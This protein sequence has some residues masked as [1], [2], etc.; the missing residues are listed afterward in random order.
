V[1]ATSEKG[2]AICHATTNETGRCYMYFMNICTWDPKDE[3]KVRE[4]RKKWEWPKKVKVMFEFVDLQGCRVINVVDTDERG[5]IASR[6][7]WVDTLKFETFP[8]YPIGDT[9][10][11]IS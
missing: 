11:K 2:K 1:N 5:L 6:S 8:V 3:K 7:D 4:R 9:K 10:K